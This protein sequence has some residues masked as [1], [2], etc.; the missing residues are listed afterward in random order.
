MYPLLTRRDRRGLTS[1]WSAGR[2]GGWKV[3]RGRW[4]GLFTDEEELS[5]GKEAGSGLERAEPLYFFGAHLAG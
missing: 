1:Q 2:A 3:T 5:R 4:F